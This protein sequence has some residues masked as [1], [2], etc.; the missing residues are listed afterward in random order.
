MSTKKKPAPR[1]AAPQRTD[2]DELASLRAQVKALSRELAECTARAESFGAMHDKLL[3][4]L[5]RRASGLPI[6]A[7]MMKAVL[8]IYQKPGT[9]RTLLE[10]VNQAIAEMRAFNGGDTLPGC[11]DPSRA[12]STTPPG[13]DS[14]AVGVDGKAERGGSYVFRGTEQAP[15]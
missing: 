15:A 6:V 5:Q 12:G 11:G 13:P 4:A 2:A 8:G 1:T 10:A 3:A 7:D 14:Y 9:G